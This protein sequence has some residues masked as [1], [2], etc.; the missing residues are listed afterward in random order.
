M[1]VD[2][3]NKVWCGDVRQ[4]FLV[5]VNQCNCYAGIVLEFYQELQ[6]SH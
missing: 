3:M 1:V 4:N 2:I 5:H 6:F